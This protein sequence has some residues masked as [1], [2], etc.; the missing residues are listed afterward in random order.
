MLVE[1]THQLPGNQRT[2]RSI[3]EIVMLPA[4]VIDHVGRAPGPA[5]ERDELGAK[6]RHVDQRAGRELISASV[7]L[8]GVGSSP[9]FFQAHFSVSRSGMMASRPGR[10][11]LSQVT[12]F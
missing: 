4:R 9:A 11:G 8:R 1:R 6:F 5:F 10:A 2:E 7:I 12:I 3:R